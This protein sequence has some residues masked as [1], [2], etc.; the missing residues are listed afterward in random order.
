MPIHSQQRTTTGPQQQG[1]GTSPGRGGGLQSRL[2]N[3]ALADLLSGRAPIDEQAVQFVHQGL[4]LREGMRGDGL[5]R[6]QMLMGIGPSGQDGAFGPGTAGRVRLFQQRHGLPATGEIDAATLQALEAQTQGDNGILFQHA[7]EGASQATARQERLQAGV[8]A[9][10]SMAQTDRQRVLAMK[11]QLTSVARKY[12]F[13]PALLAAIASRETRGGTALDS[14]G[15]SRWD[16]QGFGVMQV[17]KN[18]HTPQG[19]PRSTEHIEQAAQILDGM[20]QSMQRR[21]PEWSKDQLLQ[22]AVA[23]YNKGPNVRSQARVDKGT[24]GGD[25]SSDV[26]ARAREYARDF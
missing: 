13:P 18:H 12:D 17:D 16:G 7:T 14:E 22:A 23:S 1:P 24:T 11:Q 2:G 19:G 26:W 8:G 5:K 6:L 4:V 15:Y 9:S 20:R 25:Y 10:E 21:H 3:Q